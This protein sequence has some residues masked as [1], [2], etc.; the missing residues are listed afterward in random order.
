MA[1]VFSVLSERGDEMTNEIR[2][3]GPGKFS[4]I[5]DSYAYDASLDCVED[6]CGEADCGGWYGLLTA[7]DETGLLSMVPHGRT[8]LSESQFLKSQAGC[9]LFEDSQGF[10]DVTYYTDRDELLADWKVLSSE[11]EG[12]EIS[13]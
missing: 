8:T 2:S 13:E 4:T 1:W 3:Y 6:Q 11:V 5:I 9:I 10:V 7:G 12:M